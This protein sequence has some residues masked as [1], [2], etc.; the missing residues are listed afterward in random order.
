MKI[1]VD[2]DS[3]P[4]YVR[5]IVCKAALKKG[6]AA[7]FVAN[8]KISLMKDPLILMVVTGSESQSADNY[9][10]ENSS[11]EDLVIT[12]DIP[13]AHDLV[14]NDMT[15]INDRGMLFDRN[16][17]KERLSVRN[18][19]YEMRVNG[20]QPEKSGKLNQKDKQNFANRFDSILAKK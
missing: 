1:F 3:C 9:I 10:V 6:L 8:R 15:V 5:V 7:V 2:A 4:P 17:I 18:L 16:N 20:L 13:L 12:R 19:M 11:R 14:M